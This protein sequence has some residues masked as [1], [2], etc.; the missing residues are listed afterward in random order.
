MILQFK[1]SHNTRYSL[2]NLICGIYDRHA[3]P[4][5]NK[6][7]LIQK[8]KFFSENDDLAEK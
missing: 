2:R 7:A 5:L 3:L 8:Q 6:E 4:S 1:P